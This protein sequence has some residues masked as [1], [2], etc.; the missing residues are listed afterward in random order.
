MGSPPDDG[1]QA[2]PYVRSA[3]HEKA[4][5]EHSEVEDMKVSRVVIEGTQRMRGLVLV[6]SLIAALAVGVA[7]AS[8]GG[9]S[10][11]DADACRNGGW[12]DLVGDYAGAFKNQGDCVTFVGRGGTP[13]PKSASQLTCESYGGTFSTDPATSHFDNP[14]A[15]VIWTCNGGDLTEPNDAYV[16][17]SCVYHEHGAYA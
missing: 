7:T 12:H 11:A 4:Q 13:S 10:S 16:F 3:T 1:G 5:I 2:S 15:G 17:A 14:L 8:A 9:G 6:G